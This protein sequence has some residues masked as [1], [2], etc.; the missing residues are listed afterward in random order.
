MSALTFNNW[1]NFTTGASLQAFEAVIQQ[2]TLLTSR[3]IGGGDRLLFVA[4]G[5]VFG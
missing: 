1:K 3:R 5:E 4:G 2:S